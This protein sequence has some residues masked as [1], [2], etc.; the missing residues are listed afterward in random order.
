MSNRQIAFRL[1]VL[2]GLIMAVATAGV[3][4]SLGTIIAIA[5]AVAFGIG[6]YW[7]DT[8]VLTR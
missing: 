5:V 6:G 4:A 7:F 8:R 3:E 1:G 2:Y